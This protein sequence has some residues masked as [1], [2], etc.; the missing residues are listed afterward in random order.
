MCHWIWY[1]FPQ[2]RSL[3]RS[4]RA[5]YF[6]IAD[7]AEARLYLSNELLGGRLREITGVLLSHKGKSAESIL[8]A[9][10]A[11]KVR[12]CMTLFDHICPN[13]IFAE[14]LDAFYNA[15][16]CQTTINELTK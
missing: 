16:R 12:S 11:L 8:G 6:G 10:D 4:S 9:I 2:L 3:G 7:E 5:L 13:D 1:I 15:E 14:V